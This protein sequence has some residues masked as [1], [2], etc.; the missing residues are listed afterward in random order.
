MVNT[1][2]NIRLLK[3]EP[4]ML[5]LKII[6]SLVLLDIHSN[7]TQYNTHIYIY[8]TQYRYIPEEVAGKLR[9]SHGQVMGKSREIYGQVEEH[10][11][12]VWLYVM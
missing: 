1:I 10:Q 8:D 5:W 3:G 9:E 12:Y 4:C 2:A 11:L 6:N 7:D